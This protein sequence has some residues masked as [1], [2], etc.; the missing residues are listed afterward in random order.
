MDR[1]T[2]EFKIVLHNLTEQEAEQIED[3]LLQL[4][5]VLPVMDYVGKDDPVALDQ[6]ETETL[7]LPQR[8]GIR[9]ETAAY[10]VHCD[11][12]VPVDRNKLLDEIFDLA[13]LEFAHK[14]AKYLPNGIKSQIN[15]QMQFVPIPGA[16]AV[17]VDEYWIED[18]GKHNGQK[19]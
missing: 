5:D 10:Q 15:L 6:A 4:G 11:G 9:F 8:K 17:E 13:H 1:K 19:T 2:F 14:L 18:K 16:H 7:Q 3:T 12:M